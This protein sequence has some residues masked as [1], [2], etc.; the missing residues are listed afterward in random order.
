VSLWNIPLAHYQGFTSYNTRDS[1]QL[2]SE[3][4]DNHCSGAPHFA[5]LVDATRSVGQGA[6]SSGE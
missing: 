4:T 1:I 3:E 2:T 6:A 5:Y